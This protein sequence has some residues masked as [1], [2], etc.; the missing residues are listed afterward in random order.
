M[1]IHEVENKKYGLTGLLFLAYWFVKSF[2]TKQSGGVQIGDYIFCLSFLCFLICVFKQKDFSALFIKDCEL[3]L[4]VL[5]VVFINTI[6][7]VLYS[8][9]G[10]LISIL[11]FVFNLS[12]VIEFRYLAKFNDFIN[13]FFFVNFACIVIQFLIYAL[14]I[15]RWYYGD[16]YMGTFNDPNQLAF[17]LMSRFFIIFIIYSRLNKQR[18]KDKFLVAISLI[19]T[20]FLIVQSASTGMLLGMVVFFIA[21][22]WSYFFNKNFNLKTGVIIVVLI[23]LVAFLC[24]GGDK[25]ILKES[26]ISERIK[27]KIAMLVG[28]GQSNGFIYDRN[29]GA[30]FYKPYYILFGAGEGG[31]FRFTDVA[32]DLELHSTILS[33]LFYYGIVPYIIL[34]VW[35]IKNLRQLS[36]VEISIYIAIFIEMFTLVNHRQASLWILFVL[37]SV[38]LKNNNT[39]QRDCSKDHSCC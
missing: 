9:I 10:F 20:L 23:C 17:F 36:K 7:A 33:L 11:Y 1:V 2:Y 13:K 14:G 6:Y 31:F 24:L 4:F 25:L 26:F 16:R 5:C 27:E 18:I 30:F 22:L 12:A 29:L 15:G 32:R 19:L 37:P 21:W 34:S 8:N 39:G 35:V 28:N 38:L 3:L